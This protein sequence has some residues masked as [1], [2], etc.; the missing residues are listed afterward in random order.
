MAVG[1]CPNSLVGMVLKVIRWAAVPRQ[2]RPID[3]DTGGRVLVALR[4]SE[5][6]DSRPGEAWSAPVSSPTPEQTRVDLV[7]GAHDRRRLQRSE[8]DF[9]EGFREVSGEW[10]LED[11]AEF[12]EWP[13]PGRVEVLGEAC[14]ASVAQG[15]RTAALDRALGQHLADHDQRHP[16]TTP[17]D[18]PVAAFR[19]ADALLQR[20]HSRRRAGAAHD[21]SPLLTRCH[22][23]VVNSPSP[24]ACLAAATRRSVSMC[25]R[26]S[27]MASATACAAKPS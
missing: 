27:R 3:L 13:N 11:A 14:G 10:I 8:A 12:G 9:C 15:H 18:H 6:I 19:V 7:V 5:V 21:R 2:R 20:A 25:P 26:H 24:R 22:S 23:V 1:F 16:D 17:K 4:E